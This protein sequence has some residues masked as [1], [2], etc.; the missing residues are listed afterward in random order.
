MFNKVNVNAPPLFKKLNPEETDAP[1]V[2]FTETEILTF[3][4]KI[5]ESERKQVRMLEVRQEYERIRGLF[6]DC[7]ENQLSLLEGSIWEA[8]RLRVELD[9]L[10]EIVKTTGLIKVDPKNPGRQKELPVSKQITRVRAN[11]LNYIAKL[12]NILGKVVHEEDDGL[13]DYE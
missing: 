9:S 11:Y 5:L 2:I 4:R 12:A 3:S 1:Q 10:H 8:A 13:S 6:T 7:D